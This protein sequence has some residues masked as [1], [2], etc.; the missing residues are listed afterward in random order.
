MSYVREKYIRGYGPYCYEVKSLR[1][2]ETVKQKHIRYLGKGARLGTTD[3]KKLEKEANDLQFVA[4]R[5]KRYSK[6]ALKEKKFSENDM[7]QAM[8]E[9]EPARAEDDRNELEIDQEF[10][11]YREDV[12]ELYNGEA[13]E[14]RGAAREI[15]EEKKRRKDGG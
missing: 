8:K 10:S 3:P 7:K 11:E 14:Y 1:Q 15:N 2:G 9:G 13:E 5:Q 4:G 6:E 12:S